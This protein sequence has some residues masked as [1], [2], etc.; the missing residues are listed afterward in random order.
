M[1]KRSSHLLLTARRS[2][3]VSK[4]DFSVNCRKQAKWSIEACQRPGF[5][6][7]VAVA[8]G[9]CGALEIMKCIDNGSPD[10]L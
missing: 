3:D 1:P 4:Y 6:Q 7:F 9:D 2:F 5:L 10:M 8:S